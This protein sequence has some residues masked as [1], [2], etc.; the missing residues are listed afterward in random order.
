M[1]SLLDILQEEQKLVREYDRIIEGIEILH[2]WQEFIYM[3]LADEERATMDL[4][5]INYDIDRLTDKKLD[6][7]KQ[8]DDISQQLAGYINNLIN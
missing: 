3:K 8:L 2:K 5:R 1:K 6:C 4:E 7:E